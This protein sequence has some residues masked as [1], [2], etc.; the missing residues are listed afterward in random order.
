M[1]LAINKDYLRQQFLNLVK[2]PSPTGHEERIRDYLKGVLQELGVHYREDEAGVV[3]GYGFNNII[4]TFNG[5]KS[6]GLRLGFFAHLDTVTPT[7]EGA[8]ILEDDL[9]RTDGTS[10]LGADDKSGVAVMLELIRMM[11]EGFIPPCD[12]TFVFTGGEEDGL[13]G[14][15]GLDIASLP[16]DAAIVLDCARPIGHFVV[17]GPGYQTVTATF[18]GKA[19]HAGTNPEGGIHAHLMAAKALCAIS[20]GRLDSNS[21]CNFIFASAEDKTNI[22]P[23]KAVV[24]GEIRSLDSSALA[25]LTS[26]IEKTFA[27]AAANSGGSLQWQTTKSF[28]AFKL[29]PEAPIVQLC[30]KAYTRCG[31]SPTPFNHTG[32]SDANNLNA[33]G[34]PAVNLG[35]SINDCHSTRESFHLKNL[36]KLA[37]VVLMIILQ[38]SSS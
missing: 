13:Y 7:R 28:D 18:I 29:Q 30:M 11:A 22:I 23:E 9:V 15:A 37:D 38:A 17:A 35:M 19:S 6:T 5:E 16:I 26:Q 31:I 24:R 21:T 8:V 33:K 20:M 32:G 27:E 25:G 4:C 3:T 14:S 34:L 10:V 1:V 36:E 12:V 2:I